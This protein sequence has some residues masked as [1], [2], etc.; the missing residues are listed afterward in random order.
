M[1]S[2][3]HLFPH[4]ILILLFLAKESI[5]AVI[6]LCPAQLTSPLGHSKS[7]FCFA[8]HLA[9]LLAD[10]KSNAFPYG[11][12]FPATCTPGTNLSDTASW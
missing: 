6:M 3:D 10:R 5:F 4:T 12:A 11:Q 1:L 9:Q 2:I 7:S 8:G